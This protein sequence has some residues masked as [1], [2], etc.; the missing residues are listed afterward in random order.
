MTVGKGVL[1]GCGVEVGGW[2]VSDGWGGGFVGEAVG[3]GTVVT[4]NALIL[5]TVTFS[6]VPG[7]QPDKMRPRIRVRR[8]VMV[9]VDRRMNKA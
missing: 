7:W 2:G 8:K 3:V 1:V 4:L 9:F 5:V 6:A